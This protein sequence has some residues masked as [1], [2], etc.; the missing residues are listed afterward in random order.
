[1]SFLWRDVAHL[2]SDA[3]PSAAMSLRKM[4][5]AMGRR[6]LLAGLALGTAL[7]MSP[8]PRARAADAGGDGARAFVGDTADKAI[9]LMANHALPDAQRNQQFHDIFVA[10]FDLPA[11]GEQVLGRYWKA[12]TPEQKAQF[13]KLFEQEQVLIWAGRFKSYNGEKLTVESASADG[14]GWRVVSHIDKSGAQPIPM[15]WKVTQAG[16]G[17]RVTDLTVEGA[18][19]ALTLR[20]DFASVIQANDGKIDAL[21]GA[22]QKKIDQLGTG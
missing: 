22:M 9:A 21:F 2:V 16:G 6:D 13:L 17:W 15:E 3:R 5:I 11:I 14:A 18:S 12:A 20:Q 4:P 10:T 19:M 8:S 1:M 7:A